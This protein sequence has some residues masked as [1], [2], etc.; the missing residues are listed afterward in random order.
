MCRSSRDLPIV[1]IAALGGG[2]ALTT[3]KTKTSSM[4]S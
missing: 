1:E 3:T 2:R 4:E